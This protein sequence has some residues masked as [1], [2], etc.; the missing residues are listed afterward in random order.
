MRS[1]Y[2]ITQQYREQLNK[3]EESEG[4]LTPEL[5][6]ELMIVEKELEQKSI[7]YGL[8]IK[9]KENT[10]EVIK[11]EIKRLQKL[12]KANQKRIDY[13]K[14]NIERA[15][16]EFG[17][18]KVESDLINL[19]LRKSEKIEIIN[20]KEIPAIYMREKITVTPDKTK[21]KKAIKNHKLIS[22]ALLVENQNLQIK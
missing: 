14:S 1:L 11:N 10:I 19:S 15:M 9:E 4:L 21:I 6:E 18:K 13:L 3:L 2:N 12:L 16:E 22:G 17:V 8:Y 20:E 5:E 7:N